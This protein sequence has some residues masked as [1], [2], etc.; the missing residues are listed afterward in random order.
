MPH[1][2]KF[3]TEKNMFHI[4][5]DLEISKRHFITKCRINIKYQYEINRV[6]QG[7]L[8][9]QITFFMGYPT[10]NV[11]PKPNLL[12]APEGNT[13]YVHILFYILHAFI[14]ITWDIQILC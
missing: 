5:P 3:Y 14:V 8:E 12:Y 13:P 2:L 11:P 10:K 9:M 6:P 1:N 4:Y 7:P